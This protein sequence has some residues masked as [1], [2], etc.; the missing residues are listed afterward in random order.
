MRTKLIFLTIALLLPLAV[1]SQERTHSQP[2]FDGKIVPKDRAYETFVSSDANN[3]NHIT[4]FHSIRFTADRSEFKR[5]TDLIMEDANDAISKEMEIAQ[6][7]LTYALLVLPSSGTLNRFLGF[8]AKP[9]GQDGECSAIVV[10]IEGFT[11]INN[12]KKN[13]FTGK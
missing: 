7:N 3:E 5:V 11:T 8:Q 10:Y 13:Y 2:I 12:L 4:L 9:S 1:W 6:G